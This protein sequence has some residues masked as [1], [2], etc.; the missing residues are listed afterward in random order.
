MAQYRSL[1]MFGL[2]ALVLLGSF[3]L[4]T[5]SEREKAIMFR[6]GEI[7]RTDFTPGLYF[8]IPF[9]NN[10]RKFDGRVLTLDAD[11]ERYLTVEKKNVSVDAFIKW[12][13]DDVANFY[14]ATGGD[15]MRAGNRLA[16][17]IRDGMKAEFGKRTIQ[18]VVSGERTEI[19]E[20]L[21]V[22]ANIQAA[23]LGIAIVDVRIKRID[24]PREVSSSVFQRMRAE[25]E[26]VARDFRSR[27]QEAAE[28][29]RAD[30]DRQRTVILAEAYREAEQTRGE[31]DAKAAETYAAA[32]GDDP[33]FYAL[34][35]SLNA[36]RATFNS[37]D[38]MM[39]I[40]P[41]SDFFRYFKDPR[42]GSGR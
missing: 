37:T 9:I 19:M 31:G 35:R 11:P 4:F 29:I 33:E 10:V 38:D 7:V 17:I 16:Q 42:G 27:G 6:L 41:D 21:T 3:A 40:E 26:R 15:E 24:L 22:G 12:R 5:V 1:A 14:R 39:V 36:Y 20:I 8:K 25:R 28:R 23:E 32:Y 2:M 18:E 30:A 34:Y 13:I